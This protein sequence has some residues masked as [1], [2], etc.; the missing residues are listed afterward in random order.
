MEQRLL[1]AKHTCHISVSSVVSVQ[2]I[3]RVL[4][5]RSQA[6]QSKADTNLRACRQQFKRNY[7]KLVFVTITFTPGEVVLV[8]QPPFSAA[9]GHSVNTKANATYRK[10][11]K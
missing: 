7:D 9:A 11:L 4:E 6:L 2:A 10:L 8:Y 3:C 5:V 1:L